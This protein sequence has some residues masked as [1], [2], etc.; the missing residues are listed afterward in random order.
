M[1]NSIK[2]QVL[3]M[4]IQHPTESKTSSRFPDLSI[5]YTD[6]DISIIDNIKDVARFY[7]LKP[8]S[9]LIA[10]C[11]RGRVS[12]TINDRRVELNTGSI[13]L[14]PPKVNVEHCD[15]TA[16]FE[17]KVLSLSDYIVQHLLRDKIDVWHRSIYVNQTNIVRMSETCKE[18]FTFYYALL[19]SKIKNNDSSVSS[20]EIVQALIRVLLLELCSILE[21]MTDIPSEK[22]M[23]QGKQL[24]NKYLNI[25][26]TNEVKRQPIAQYA[27]QLAITPKYL[28]MLCLKYSGKTAS[29]WVI[30]YTIEDIR[31]YLKNTGL[32]IK[33]IAAKMGFANMSHFG[34]YVRKHL[35]MSPSDFRE[36]VL[37]HTDK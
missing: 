6:G 8:E 29:D 22:K 26:S 33:E 19:R 3:A 2:K 7:P 9:N 28:T 24:F 13:L 36:Q 17:C 18:D 35:G 15:S 4:A 34:S 11:C 27:S 32:S 25:I 37:M 14:L 21:H 31:F 30:Q 12:M 16:D 10:L 5:Q 1:R 20:I 23:S